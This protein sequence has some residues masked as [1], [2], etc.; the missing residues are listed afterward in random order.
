MAAVIKQ[1]Y[2]QEVLLYKNKTKERK[3]DKESREYT[4]MNWLRI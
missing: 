3:P 4:K 2:Q 1:K